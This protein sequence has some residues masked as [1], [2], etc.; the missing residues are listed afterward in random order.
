MQYFKKNATWK[1]FPDVSS[2]HLILKRKEK[3]R[4]SNKDISYDGMS[5][6]PYGT[7]YGTKKPKTKHWFTTSFM[8]QSIYG[9]CI[10]NLLM[11]FAHEG[12]WAGKSIS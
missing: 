6:R 4:N 9:F 11:Y 10:S 5:C 8:K 1:T 12:I 7:W 3:K 2:L